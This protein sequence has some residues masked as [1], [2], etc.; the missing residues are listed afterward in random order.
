VLALEGLTPPQKEEYLQIQLRQVFVE[1]SV[2]ENP[3]PV[4]LP[5]EVWEKLSRDKEIH[6]DDLPL[7]ITLDDVR[8]AREAYYEKPSRPVLNVLTDSRYPHTI[9]LGDPG[10]G[11]STL[12][13]YVILSL[14][15]PTPTPA[16]PRPF[17][18]VRR[19][20]GRSRK[21]RYTII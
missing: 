11:K 2:R 15:D 14:I 4:E 17:Y 10:S 7:G 5:K 9:I 8:E 12:A 13:R 6:P 20:V 19:K 1:Q 3:P 18:L 21:R 16:L